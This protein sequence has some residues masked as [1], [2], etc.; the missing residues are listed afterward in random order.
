M[1][2]IFFTNVATVTRYLAGM[3]A[4]VIYTLYLPTAIRVCYFNSVH[5]LSYNYFG[6]G[7]NRNT[8]P[9]CTDWQLPV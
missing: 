3:D 5:N 6:C 7:R 2:L 1:E 8:T 9:P 4:E